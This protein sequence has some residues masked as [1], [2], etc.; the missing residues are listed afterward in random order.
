VAYRAWRA[1]RRRRWGGALPTGWRA[2]PV[3]PLSVRRSGQRSFP[4]GLLTTLAGFL[5]SGLGA[6]G[7]LVI[8]GRTLG[9]ARY[10]TIAAFWLLVSLVTP[11][12]LFPL[13][14]ELMRAYADRYRRGVGGR[15]V[16]ARA[17]VL[18]GGV[19]AIVLVLGIAAPGS[20]LSRLFDG[21]LALMVALALALIGYLGQQ[22][23]CGS[24][25][26]WQGAAVLCGPMP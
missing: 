9:P 16:L 10:S 22:L 18:G 6:Y 12:L 4:P 8:A 13:Q 15:P 26:Q 23:V 7:F 11:G 24:P 25:W 1:R 21:N 17:A 2:R 5:A 3:T 19:T 20:V 14:Q